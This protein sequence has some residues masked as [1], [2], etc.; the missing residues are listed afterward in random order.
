MREDML[1]QSRG[2]KYSVNDG[3]VTSSNVDENQVFSGAQSMDTLLQDMSVFDDVLTSDEPTITPPE[4]PSE[5]P[6]Q[7]PPENPS[8]PD[9]ETPPASDTPPSSTDDTPPATES[10][11][12]SNVISSKD[13]TKK[14]SPLVLILIILTTIIALGVAGFLIFN[15]L[16]TE[17]EDFQLSRTTVTQVQLHLERSRTA[18]TNITSSIPSDDISRVEFEA[19]VEELSASSEALNTSLVALSEM[20]ALRDADINSQYDTFRNL[21]SVYTDKIDR[22]LIVFPAL[23]EFHAAIRDLDLAAVARGDTSSV[24]AAVSHLTNSPD[25]DAHQ[26]GVTWEVAI[27]A[28]VSAYLEF[29]ADPTPE[30]A[31]IFAEEHHRFT[32]SVADISNVTWLSA[33]IITDNEFRT[34]NYHLDKLAALIDDRI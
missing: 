15:N 34:L 10:I 5:S 29:E 22:T 1:D 17:R 13:T 11:F 19:M 21:I 20:S 16:N 2:K 8:T 28:F 23:F 14:K 25:P 33:I 18:A 31:A 9:H 4:T 3:S 27:L 30:N 6:D 12:A 32:T 7:T 26:L 24:D